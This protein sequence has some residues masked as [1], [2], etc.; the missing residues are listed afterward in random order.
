M[1]LASG[2]LRP[3]CDGR[4]A[5]KHSNGFGLPACAFTLSGVTI[6]NLLLLA[7][8]AM[9]LVGDS[10]AEDDFF[11]CTRASPRTLR[12]EMGV[13]ALR[14]DTPASCLM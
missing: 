2:P 1:S 6:R 3:R 11:F 14:S 7:L 12:I 8:L 9:E 10:D 5:S 4:M 13:A